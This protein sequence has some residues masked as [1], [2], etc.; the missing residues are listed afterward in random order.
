MITH[1]LK[2]R[3][4]TIL[5]GVLL[6]FSWY[7]NIIF[8]KTQKITHP[9]GTSEKKKAK[10]NIHIGQW[11]VRTLEGTVILIFKIKTGGDN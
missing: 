10:N 6:V 7:V 3:N 1:H 11:E 2:L 9:I 8:F 4:V 5:L